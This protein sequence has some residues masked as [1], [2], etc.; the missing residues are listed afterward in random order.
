MSIE[1]LDQPK[2]P[3]GLEKNIFLPSNVNQLQKYVGR[4]R[5]ETKLGM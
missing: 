2:E 4:K 5:D 1:L 3:R